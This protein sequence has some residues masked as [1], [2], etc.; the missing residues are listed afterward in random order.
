MTVKKNQTFVPFTQ[1]LQHNFK[2]ISAKK[3]KKMNAMLWASL[4]WSHPRTSASRRPSALAEHSTL[5]AVLWEF[6]AGHDGA[7]PASDSALAELQTIA[8][9][10][11]PKHGVADVG[12]LPSETLE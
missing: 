6:Q 3:Q 5:T 8:R 1:A 4:G 11:L 9:D 2:S 10:I 7:L 12:L